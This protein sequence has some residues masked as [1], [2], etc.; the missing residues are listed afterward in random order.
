M[1]WLGW[2]D[3]DRQVALLPEAKW[4]SCLA[5]NELRAPNEKQEHYAVCVYVVLMLPAGPNYRGKLP[6]LFK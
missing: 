4:G 1:D 2:N 5:F 6:A 3:G